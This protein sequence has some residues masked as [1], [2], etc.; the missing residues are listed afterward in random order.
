MSRRQLRGLVRA[1]RRSSTP[2]I[3]STW[4]PSGFGRCCER[5]ANTPRIGRLASPR[6]C[7][8]RT[9]RF[10]RCSQVITTMSSPG[11]RPSSAGRTSGLNISQQSGEPSSPW[12]GAACGSVSGDSTNPMGRSGYSFI[13]AVETDQVIVT[14]PSTTMVCPVTKPPASET[15]HTRVAASSTGEPMRP[16]NTRGVRLSI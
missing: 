6:G 8:C 1:L 7:T 12:R 2:R 3:V 10:A 13:G 16:N 11:C 5:V 15:S 9:V 14:P 4:T